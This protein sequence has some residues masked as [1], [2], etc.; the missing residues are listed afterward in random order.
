MGYISII[1]IISSLTFWCKYLEHFRCCKLSPIA[2]TSKVMMLNVISLLGGVYMI[3]GDF[4]PGANSLR[5]LVALHSFTW[6]YQKMSYLRDFTR[7]LYRSENFIPGR[8]PASVSCKRGTTTRFG[9]N[10]TS[11]W[12]W[13]GSA[14]VNFVNPKWRV[15]INVKCASLQ[16]RYEIK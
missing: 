2:S 3:P 14:C 4:R 11:G 10:L 5:F 15:L 16:A 6:Y 13:T 7:F 1:I 8:N 9:R 12:T